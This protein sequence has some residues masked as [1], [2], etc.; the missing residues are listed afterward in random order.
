MTEELIRALAR[1]EVLIGN[2]GKSIDS[3]KVELKTIAPRLDTLTAEV[4]GASER[5]HRIANVMQ[6]LTNETAELAQAKVAFDKA[7]DDFT[8]EARARAREFELTQ[9]AFDTALTIVEGR[10]RQMRDDMADA[11]AASEEGAAPEEEAS[12]VIDKPRM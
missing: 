8:I 11:V 2:L 12:G 5:V 9:K 1:L 7:L 6:A 10:V 4:R 3:A